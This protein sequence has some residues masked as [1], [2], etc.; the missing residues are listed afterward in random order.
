MQRKVAVY[1]Q[2]ILESC[3]FVIADISSMTLSEFSSNRILQDAVI[4]RFEI[5]GEAVKHVPTELRK[6]YP[7]ATWKDAAAFRDVLT[8]DYPEIVIDEVYHTAFRDLP[9]FRAQIARVL[10]DLQKQ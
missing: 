5:I 2:D 4:R 8:H 9:A 7:E 6:K 1:L 10:N 3:D